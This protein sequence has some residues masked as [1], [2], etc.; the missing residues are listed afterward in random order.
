MVVSG[1]T[2]VSGVSWM[3]VLF[4]RGLK[5]VRTIL[6]TCSRCLF[7]EDF[8][9]LFEFFLIKCSFA[10]LLS[11]STNIGAIFPRLPCKIPS[12]KLQISIVGRESTHSL[13]M[14]MYSHHFSILC[15]IEI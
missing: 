5:I 11:C 8:L 6:S 10:K 3:D 12:L 13:M 4:A 1:V 15:F 7:R 14:K 2:G 9:K